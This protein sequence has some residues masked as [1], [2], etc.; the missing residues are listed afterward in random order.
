MELAKSTCKNKLPLDYRNF[1]NILDKLPSFDK[2]YEFREADFATFISHVAA[3][4]EAEKIKSYVWQRRI[5]EAEDMPI[6]DQVRLMKAIADEMGNRSL[7]NKILSNFTR[8]L[9]FQ[10]AIN[11]RLTPILG[12]SR[13]TQPGRRPDGIELH[14]PLGALVNI[15]KRRAVLRPVTADMAQDRAKLAPTGPQSK[16]PVESIA[17]PEIAP[18]EAQEA[19]EV[20]CN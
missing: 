17:Q 3:L 4:P 1:A 19:H 7:K 9:D 16:N 11:R 13:R 5:S 20:A 15:G 18:I 2:F 6:V 8:R 12:A 14:E 10:E